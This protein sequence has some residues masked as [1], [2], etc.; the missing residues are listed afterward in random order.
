MIL[1]IGPTPAAQ[2]VMVFSK[3]TIDAVNRAATTLDG[4]AGKSINVAKVLKALGEQPLATGFLGGP[5]GKELLRTLRERK[6][7]CE[8]VSVAAQTRQCI[9]VIDET[10][11]R[12]TELVEES[13]PV[14][15]AAYADLWHIIERRMTTS[16]AAVMSGTI[17]P[18][19]PIDF[20]ERCTRLAHRSSALAI[21]DA[22]GPAL[23]HALKA[24]PSLVKPNRA[25]LAVTVK[26]KLVGL[27]DLKRAMKAL[28]DQ[29]AERIVVTAGKAATLAFDGHRFWRITNPIIEARNPIGSG[30]SFTAGLI[31]RLLRGDDLGESCRWAAA[32]GTANALTWMAGEVDLAGIRRLAKQVHVE[33]C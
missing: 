23:L 14:P 32:A 16:R 1:C 20:Y 28:N 8:F 10:S 9:T 19:G 5:R 27:A 21:V 33:T 17:T 2:R 18:G 3:L 13:Q 31:W 12:H 24:K 11:A 29:G 22:Q 26:R 4:A 30:D 25:E 15:A 7:R 6:I